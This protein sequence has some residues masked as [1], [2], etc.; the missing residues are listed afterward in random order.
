MAAF[1]GPSRALPIPGDPS[2]P[3][4]RAFLQHSGLATARQLLGSELQPSR[5]S[6]ISLRN[7]SWL[8]LAQVL[9]VGKTLISTQFGINVCGCFYT[10]GM[11]K[12]RKRA[13]GFYRPFFNWKKSVIP[14]EI[15]HVTDSSYPSLLGS[16]ALHFN[17]GRVCLI[18]TGGSID[19]MFLLPT[20]SAHKARP[21]CC[22]ASCEQ[23]PLLLGECDCTQ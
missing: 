4:L 7:P 22:R 9:W 3:R 1:P 20:R 13:T 21:C 2:G 17:E 8:N 6:H 5:A 15:P 14:T 16:F 18:P 19:M 12:M 23:K 10:A 11:E